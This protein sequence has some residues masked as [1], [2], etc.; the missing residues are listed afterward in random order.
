MTEHLLCILLGVAAGTLVGFCL[1]AV[2][3]LF[4]DRKMRGNNGRR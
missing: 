2:I 1:P 4:D 3:Y